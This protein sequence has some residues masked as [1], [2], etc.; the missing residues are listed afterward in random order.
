MHSSSSGLVWLMP[1]WS[2]CCLN[3]HRQHLFRDII[4]VWS[5]FGVCISVAA[6]FRPAQMNHTK[7]GN[8]LECYA[9]W[10]LNETGLKAPKAQDG[11][12]CS[13]P[14]VLGQV[15]SDC[16]VYMQEYQTTLS[17]CVRWLREIQF[18]MIL[19]RLTRSVCCVSLCSNANKL[20]LSH[21][22]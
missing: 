20:I 9:K 18:H 13:M 21:V 8:E 10:E 6:A 14:W 17:M 11:E 2:R 19:V 1:G 16:G 22:M 4:L 7:G 5:A 3:A 15:G 12:L